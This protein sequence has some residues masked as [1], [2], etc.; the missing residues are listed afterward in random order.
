[1]IIPHSYPFVIMKAV[2]SINSS[3]IT[4]SA[5]I[6]SPGDDSILEYG[7]VWD[8]FNIPT[9]YNS[10]YAIKGK[11]VTGMYEARITRYIQKGVTYE[12]RPYIISSGYTV[13]GN[14]LRFTGE[15]SIPPTLVDFMPKSGKPGSVVTITVKNLG[16]NA[17]VFFSLNKARVLAASDT[18][19][20]VEVPNVYGNT[21]ISVVQNYQSY[22]FSRPFQIISPW[23]DISVA[24]P[25]SSQNVLTGF[26]INGKGYLITGNPLSGQ[27]PSAEVWEY[28]TD[29]HIWKQ[30]NDF[31]G[32]LR[33]N[34]ISFVIGEKAY[35]GL[36]I[37][38]E[39]QNKIV[40]SKVMNDLWEYDPSN[41][42]W[43]QKSTFPY[44]YYTF[45]IGFTNGTIAYEGLGLTYDLNTGKYGGDSLFWSYSP[46]EDRWDSIA[47]CPVAIS[48]PVTAFTLGN[49]SYVGFSGSNESDLYAYDPGSQSWTNGLSYP[50]QGKYG[51]LNVVIN[52]TVYMGFG[53]DDQGFLT[54]FWSFDPGSGWTH[55]PDLLLV[56]NYLN[57]SFSA[58]DKG[59][60]YNSNNGSLWEFDPKKK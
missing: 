59:Y 43:T 58:G 12:I 31:P 54:D 28:T 36:G 3:G 5:E 27:P 13:Y 21:Y 29:T 49:V 4:A 20:T 24:A 40:V 39:V 51:V 37:K 1:M 46:A 14:V 56:G 42:T 16:P 32:P 55:L 33:E 44:D 48:N 18:S 17:N 38:K 41:D 35:Y 9:I 30:K 25:I 53:S 2:D 52:D 8:M 57:R 19:L 6:L 26:A 7:F 34:A 22:Q 47:P 50:G 15:G 11:P 45:Q 23:T 10:K 60:F